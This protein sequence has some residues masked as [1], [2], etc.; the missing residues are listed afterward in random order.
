MLEDDTADA[1][2]RSTVDRFVD[3]YAT[4]APWTI[5]LAVPLAAIAFLT[6]PVPDPSFPWATLPAAWRLP[7]TQPRIE[8][9]PVTYT[10]AIW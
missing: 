5:A 2:G 9:W 4:V 8:H 1:D 7:V 10:V 3:R 6:N